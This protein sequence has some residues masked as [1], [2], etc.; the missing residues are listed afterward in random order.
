MLTPDSMKPKPPPRDTTLSR[1][2]L[3]P[4]ASK[5]QC[6]DNEFV[7]AEELKPEQQVNEAARD[8][9]VRR[10][11]I[12]SLLF[13]PQTIISRQELVNERVI[14]DLFQEHREAGARLVGEAIAADDVGAGLRP[15]PRLVTLLFKSPEML[16][17]SG[18]PHA[19]RGAFTPESDLLDFIERAP[20]KLEEQGVNFWR[21]FI[22][23]DCD[24]YYLKLTD[25]ELSEVSERFSTFI[26][27]LCTRMDPESVA[28]VYAAVDPK[29]NADIS[30]AAKG[31]LKYLD[32]ELRPWALGFGRDPISRGNLYESHI[33]QPTEGRVS[34]RP[35]RKGEFVRPLKL[36]ADAAYNANVPTTLDR[37]SFVPGGLPDPRCLPDI[38]YKKSVF[39]DP[40]DAGQIEGAHSAISDQLHADLAGRARAHWYY[41]MQEN[42]RIPDFADLT[43]DDITRLHSWDEWKR[44]I[45]AQRTALDF[46]D[47]SKLD[48]LLSEYHES[49]F[50]FQTALSR[51][52]LPHWRPVFQ[53]KLGLILAPA[54]LLAG[55]LFAPKGAA[56]VVRSIVVSNYEQIP[57]SLDLLIAFVDEHSRPI[58]ANIHVRQTME[59][60]LRLSSE[61]I[62]QI[63]KLQGESRVLSS[64]RQAQERT[65]H[66]AFEDAA[67]DA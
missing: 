46:T 38:M 18:A 63:A 52:F 26:F 54:I 39:R 7:P 35:L 48:A 10:E 16:D 49:I 47:V 56:G 20:F 62:E 33:V 4:Y 40:A 51:N 55:T 11:F 21:S 22:G 29:P 8:R 30:E 44:M 34:R 67:V 66:G 43:L 1:S 37:Y 2:E 45:R 61:E 17:G 64:A 50:D 25:A 58:R 27:Y 53:G 9:A 41:R 15:S 3:N 28:Q 12:R 24:P 59:R 32:N 19:S 60:H 23:S 65:L 31:F 42:M 14:V 57:L 5:P 36:L 13:S 6:I